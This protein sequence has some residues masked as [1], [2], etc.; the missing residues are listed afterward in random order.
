M[1]K[2]NHRFIKKTTLDYFTLHFSPFRRFK[3]SIL[4]MKI[5]LLP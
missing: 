1:I 4:C 5:M 3:S 2:V